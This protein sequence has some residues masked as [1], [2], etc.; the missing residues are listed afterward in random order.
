[1]L[2]CGRFLAGLLVLAAAVPASAATDEGGQTKLSVLL[3][4]MPVGGH[5][6]PFATLG[7]E[8]SRRG[9]NVTLSTILSESSDFPLRYAN[10]SG[11]SFL[12]AGEN[13]YDF[14]SATKI[15]G[16]SLEFLAVNSKS[17]LGI[18]INYSRTIEK[19]L[20]RPDSWQW[21]V[22]VIDDLLSLGFKCYYRKLSSKAII[23]STTFTSFLQHP[24]PWPF[25]TTLSTYTQN[26][27]FKQ[28]LV[29]LVERILQKLVF[30]LFLE[31]A[32][33][34]G[35]NCSDTFD[36]R[37]HGVRIPELILTVFGIEYP[38]VT[39][40]MTHHV[41]PLF[42]KRN[43]PLST[44]ITDWLSDKPD[45]S[46]VYISMGTMVELSGRTAKAIVEGVTDS[47][48]YAVWSLRK[49]NRDVLEGMEIDESRFLIVEWAEQFSILGHPAV[50]LAILHGGMGGVQE[51]LYHGVPPLIVTG[52][53]IDQPAF[54]ARINYWE[55]GISLSPDQITA[56]LVTEGLEKLDTE[57][58]RE[59]IAKVRSMFEIAGGVDRAAELV[60]FYGEVGYGHL[61]P[62]FARYQWSW[63]QYYNV[64]VYALLLAA[65]LLWVYLSVRLSLC[66]CRR[67][68]ACRSTKKKTE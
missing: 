20:N 39:F 65:A 6:I 3:V 47:A 12:A 58:Y 36:I 52:Y 35:M 56:S 62:S 53:A 43:F 42:S 18:L 40:P 1:M 14:A 67:C 25:P 26:L 31:R 15:G 34:D 55:L 5:V 7:E 17:P 60:E 28:R 30:K 38:S 4:S 48:Y 46:V 57:Y 51:A 33:F 68:C 13:E 29:T 21:D 41:G 61:V 49:S 27:S 66:L 8:L 10:R 19:L 50:G 64:D 37:D 45:N 32:F 63:V 9:H 59:K 11:I 54:A 24:P 44:Q 22:I 16:N 23:L 2:E